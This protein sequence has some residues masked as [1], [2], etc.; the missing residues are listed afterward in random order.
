MAQL[1]N[2]EIVAIDG[3]T[4][5]GAKSKGKKTPIH[6]VSTF[7]CAN[8]LVLGQAKTDEKSNEITAIP[9]LLELLSL[10]NTIVSIDALGCQTDIAEKIVDKQAG[11]IFAVKVNKERFL[12]HI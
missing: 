2:K 9:K 3:K 6:M 10:E 4:L 5:R 8:N 7:A 1:T 12:E 11:C